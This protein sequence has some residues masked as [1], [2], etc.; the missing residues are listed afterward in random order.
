MVAALGLAERPADVASAAA[1]PDTGPV[2]RPAAAPVAAE[3]RPV[4]V[5]VR[6]LHVRPRTTAAVID[7]AAIDPAAIDPAAIAPAVRAPSVARTAPAS[8][9]APSPAR[10][11]ARTVRTRGS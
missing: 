4:V 7:P 3:A 6:R 9:P 11:A 5:V 1:V 2:D 10:R 8:G